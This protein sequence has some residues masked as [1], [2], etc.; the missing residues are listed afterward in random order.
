MSSWFI[1]IILKSR[2]TNYF[3]K[4][5]EKRIKGI[6]FRTERKQVSNTIWSRRASYPLSWRMYGRYLAAHCKK[7]NT[8]R[9]FILNAWFHIISS[10]YLTA[11]KLSKA[12]VIITFISIHFILYHIHIWRASFSKYCSIYVLKIAKL[13]KYSIRYMPEWH[14]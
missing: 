2:L 5:K 12:G 11:T 8:A 9:A 3:F 4:P 6:H 7:L 10:E 1:Q 13:G 14:S